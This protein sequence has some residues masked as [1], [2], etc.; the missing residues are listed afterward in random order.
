MKQ[1]GIRSVAWRTRS[2]DCAEF[3]IGRASRDPLA[4]S[5]QRLLELFGGRPWWASDG[6]WRSLAASESKFVITD[7]QHKTMILF[8]LY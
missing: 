6:Q 1:G 8:F 4:P 2:L 3:I 5:E 7:N